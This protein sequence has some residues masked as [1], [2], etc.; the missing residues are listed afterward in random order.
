MGIAPTGRIATVSLEWTVMFL[1]EACIER[2]ASFQRR[3]GLSA[4]LQRF[5]RSFR[6]GGSC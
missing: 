3:K 2:Q 4:S 1:F 5:Q 6:S